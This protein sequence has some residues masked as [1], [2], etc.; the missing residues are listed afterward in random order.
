MGTEQNAW[1]VN[2]FGEDY[3]NIYR[4]TFTAERTEKEVAFAE[5]KLE[6]DAGA[7]VIDL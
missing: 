2:F 6:L 4:H 3:L 1:Y 7:R 5:R